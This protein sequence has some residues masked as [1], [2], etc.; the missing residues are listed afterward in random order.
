MITR[1]QSLADQ[2]YME[3][4]SWIQSNRLPESGGVLPSETEL[5]EMFSTSRATIREALAELERGRLVI[6]RQGSGTY[7]SPAFHKLTRTLNGLNDPLT[8]LQWSGAVASV[9][10][11]ECTLGTASESQAASLELDPGASLVALRIL[12]L[13]EGIPAAWLQAIIP[14]VTKYANGLPLPTF[15]GLMGYARE[16]SGRSISHS[17][18]ALRALGADEQLANFLRIQKGYP[19]LALDELYLSDQ[20]SPVF[21]STLNILTDKID[22]QMLRNSDQSSNQIVIW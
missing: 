20:G 4:L 2:V 16:I 9:D 3:I 15:S 5:S 12:Y 10:R 7:V 21:Q 22:L 17:L 6:R 14:A 19:L 11:L 13:L 1:S 18:T 8:L